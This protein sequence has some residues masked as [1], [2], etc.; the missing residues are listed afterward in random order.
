MNNISRNTSNPQANFS[1]NVQNDRNSNN[2]YIITHQTELQYF[3]NSNRSPLNNNDLQSQH[4]RNLT[5]TTTQIQNGFININQPIDI[6]NI[7]PP[8]RQAQNNSSIWSRIFNFIA[9]ICMTTRH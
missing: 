3:N 4:N 7:N 5:Y 9:N 6:D 2:N 1:L 8:L